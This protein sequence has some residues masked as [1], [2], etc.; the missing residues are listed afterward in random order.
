MWCWNVAETGGR[1]AD[2]QQWM[3][4]STSTPEILRRFDPS[5]ASGG[6]YRSSRRTPDGLDKP[7]V[8]G[9]ERTGRGRGASSAARCGQVGIFDRPSRS[10]WLVRSIIEAASAAIPVDIQDSP[11]LVAVHAAFAVGSGSLA[12]TNRSRCLTTRSAG[13]LYRQ[14]SQGGAVSA[15]RPV[16]RA[17]ASERDNLGRICQ[18]VARRRCSTSQ[19][20]TAP[21]AAARRALRTA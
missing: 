4:R 7:H 9:A 12:H 14:S 8:C 15:P 13:G 1:A 20:G 18:Y 21:L 11:S 5:S 19:L 3:V 17:R 2:V 16:W 6:R 10:A